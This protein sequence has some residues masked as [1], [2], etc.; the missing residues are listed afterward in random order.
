MKNDDSPLY[1]IGMPED[2][3]SKEL[4]ISK[5]S[6][7]IQRLQKA[8]DKIEEARVSIKRTRSGGSKKN[9][10]VTILIKT[11]RKRFNFEESGWDLSNISEQLCQRILDT[12]T[13]RSNKR[14]KKTI[15]KIDEK[16]F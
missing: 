12:L 10:S 16:M 4:I 14:T 6:S 1:V 8:Y 3:F 13:K 5:L 7:A 9:Y 11:P 15:R 2:E